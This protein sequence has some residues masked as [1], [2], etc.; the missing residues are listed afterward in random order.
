M[1]PKKKEDKDAPPPE[2]T[3]PYGVFVTVTVPSAT[4]VLDVPEDDAAAQRQTHITLNIPGC[5][6]PWASPHTAPSEGGLYQYSVV[7]HFRR[8]GGDDGLMA[9]I[10]GVLTVTVNDSATNAVLASATVDQLQGFAIGQNTWSAEGLDLVPA[11][12]VPE[13]VP[14]ARSARLAFVSIALQER[15]LPEGADAAALAAAP[16]TPEAEL[17]PLLPYSYVNPAGA[18]EGNMVELAVSGLSP[19][20]PNLQAAADAA[21]GKLHVTVGLALPGGGPTV[22]VP[23]AVVG[24]RLAAPAFR[25]QLVPPACRQALQY[26]LEDGVPLVLEVARYVTAE[27]MAD[28][29]FEGYHAAA[30]APALV[31]GLGTAGATEAAAEGL[32]LTAWAAAGAK[33]CLP[34]YTAPPGKPKPVEA[35]VPPAGSCLWEK[36]GAQLAVSVRFARPVVPAWRPPPPPPRPL[37]ELIPPRDLTPKP[38]P[39]T[40]VDDFKAKVRVIARALAEEYKAVLPPPDASVA[41]AAAGGGAEGRHKALIFE[42][43]R[44]GKYAQ[45]RDSLKAAVVSLVREKYRKSGSMSP[46]EMALLYN[47]LYGS[48]LAALH[49]ALNDLVDAAAA[50]PRAPPPPPVPDK[51]RLAELLELAAQA[52]A[53]GDTDRAELLHQRRLLAQ[54]EAQVWYEYGG[55]CLRRGGARRGRAEECF[56]E[57]LALEPTHRGAL[58]ALLGCSVAAGRATDPAYLE[59]AEAAAHRLLDVAGRSSLDG[60]A[61]LAVVYRAYGEAKKAELASCEQEMARLEK[62]QLAAAA[63][64]SAGVSPSGSYAEGRAGGA[65]AGA[66]AAEASQASAGSAA[67]GAGE[68]QARSYIGLAT[69]L[70]ESLALPAEAALALEAAAGLRHWPSVGPDTRTLHALAGALAEQAL[71]RAAG[72]AAAAVA[73]GAMLTPGST[74]LGLMRGDAGGAVSAVAAEAAWRCRLLVAQLHKARGA[75]DEA[76]RFYQEY[77]EAARAAGRLAEVPLPAWLELAEAYAARGQARFAADVYLLAASARPGCAVLWRGAGRCFAGAGELGPADMALSEA[78]VLDPEEPEAWGWLALVALREGR[79]EDAEKAL[80]FGLRCGLADPGV[81]L[82]IAAEYRAAGQ[83]RAEQRVLQEVAVRLMPESCSA[84]LLLARCLVAQRCGAEAA[85]AVAA[86]RELAAHED[87]EAAVAELEAEL[88]GMA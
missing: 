40:A 37:L 74:A 24:G 25:R 22:A 85:E 75:T 1:A 68:L 43:N 86:A 55:Y 17:P 3:N 9:L 33:A 36:A 8:S 38:A 57:A 80:S 45:M 58:L 21:G 5:H 29:A 67:G 28:P 20:P 60:W 66:P 88:R 56:R 52:E 35:E 54:N 4:V 48:L 14:K 61:A 2:D 12:E 79:A 81:L 13:G 41:A 71:A 77:I 50:R 72:G 78:N 10:N 84:R 47:D 87:D 49:A 27:G 70:L 6:V 76:I 64:A 53:M 59:S 19:L 31:A 83:R 23:L 82:D 44:S 11:A 15:P 7:K 32:P 69:T 62:Q 63:A 26:A 39:T 46:N 65:G 16:P 42:L 30:A 34:P 18:E 73:A 51:Q